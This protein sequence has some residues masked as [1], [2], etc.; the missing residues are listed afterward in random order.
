[1]GREEFGDDD[2]GELDDLEFEYDFKK[3]VISIAKQMPETMKAIND[4]TKAIDDLTAVLKT[5]PKSSDIEALCTKIE[6]LMMLG[7]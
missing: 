7:R 5:M 1:M 4:S 3:A 2:D 6:R